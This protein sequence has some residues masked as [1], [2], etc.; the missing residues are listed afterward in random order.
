MYQAFI[1]AIDQ[2][3]LNFYWWKQIGM[4]CLGLAAQIS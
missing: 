3:E 2:R 1:S 4:F